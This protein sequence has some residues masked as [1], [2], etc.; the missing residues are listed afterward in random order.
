LYDGDR[1]V[2]V[3]VPGLRYNCLDDDVHV[4]LAKTLDKWLTEGKAKIIEDREAS[5]QPAQ[6]GGQGEVQ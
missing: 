5:A 6:L 4:V 2:G 1:L 3:Y